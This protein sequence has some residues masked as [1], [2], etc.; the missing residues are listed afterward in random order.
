[1]ADL[2]TILD[3]ISRILHGI[4]SYDLV[5]V[6]GNHIRIGNILLS[7]LLFLVGIKYYK[8]YTSLIGNYLRTKISD[9]DAVNA[10][11]KLILYISVFLYIITILEIANVPLNIFAFIG[12]ALAIG[13]G[14]GAQTLINNFICSL[15][16][17]VERP[18]KIGD[19]VEIEGVTG[20]ITGIGARCIILTTDS[21]V[22]VLVPN[23][24]VM[25]NTLVNWTL[26]STL[27]RHKAEITIPRE[28]NGAIQPQY[29]I[30][31]LQAIFDK[32]EFITDKSRAQVNLTKI[33]KNSLSFVMDFFC[34]TEVSQNMES[35]RNILNLEL[36]DN[37]KDYQFTVEYL[38]ILELKPLTITSDEA[39]K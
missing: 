37:L 4:L 20:T 8:N 33:N 26:S 1:M 5:H 32:L 22:E 19:T 34:H 12:G 14:L 7:I 10:L 11:E 29:F 36:L 35:F 25:Q 31:K 30:N 16:I 28:Y 39:T 13:I 18:V 27:I 23:S 2:H 17:M 6:A 38:K 3:V 9:K 24:K 21:N 15:I